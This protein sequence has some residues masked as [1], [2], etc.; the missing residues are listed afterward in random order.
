MNAFV[1]GGTGIVLILPSVMPGPGDVGPVRFRP[2]SETMADTV[3][4]FRSEYPDPGT[5]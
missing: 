2:P 5:P 4:W 3:K 1:T